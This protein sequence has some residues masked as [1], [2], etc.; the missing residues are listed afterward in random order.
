MPFYSEPS[1]DDADDGLYVRHPNMDKD[2]H[3]HLRRV[4]TDGIAR[5]AD[6]KA[7]A[8]GKYDA[9]IYRRE[10]IKLMVLPDCRVR[11]AAL[12]ADHPNPWYDLKDDDTLAGLPVQFKVWLVNEINKC[13]G[14][15]ANVS[16]VKISGKEVDF[17]RAA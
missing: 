7:N 2:E 3:V 6:E 4:L 9:A 17:R 10:L 12:P 13:D 16:K 15:I 5:L 11:N 1:K 14:S 8:D